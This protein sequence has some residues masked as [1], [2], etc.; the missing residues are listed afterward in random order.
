MWPVPE[1]SRLH[2]KRPSREP[3][4]E[5]LSLLNEKH[6]GGGSLHAPNGC[7]AEQSVCRPYCDGLLASWR[8]CLRKIRTIRK[9]QTPFFKVLKIRCYFCLS[10]DP[11][12]HA[13]LARNYAELSCPSEYDLAFLSWTWKMRG[14][15]VY[16]AGIWNSVA[17][18]PW[19][20]LALHGFAFEGQSGGKKRTL[21][22]TKK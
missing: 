13:E 19:T 21:W 16:F 5:A 9:I 15:V 14:T 10:H 6:T 20:P 4:A 7:I 8:D 2:P 12:G 3:C 18:R 17:R 22:E 11:P 1:G